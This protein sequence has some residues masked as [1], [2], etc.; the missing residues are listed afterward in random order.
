MEQILE[1]MHAS[2]A[3]VNAQSDD[4]DQYKLQQS[5]EDSDQA[6]DEEAD[7]SGQTSRQKR[8]QIMVFSATLT[9]PLHLR[10]RLNKGMSSSHARG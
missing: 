3:E 5:D 10:K 2:R 6:S 8:L 7:V 1:H 4:F 9:L